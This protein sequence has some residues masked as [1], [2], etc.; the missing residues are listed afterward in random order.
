MEAPLLGST[1]SLAWSKRWAPLPQVLMVLDT[2]TT[3]F[4]RVM[5]T[6]MMV[7]TSRTL[8]IAADGRLYRSRRH[9]RRW[10][11]PR[12]V[13]SGPR[14]REKVRGVAPLMYGS[15]LTRRLHLRRSR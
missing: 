1:A 7:Q 8:Q 15:A 5:V 13:A 3:G 12:L 6:L 10:I 4:P 11:R 2:I 14:G 9:Q